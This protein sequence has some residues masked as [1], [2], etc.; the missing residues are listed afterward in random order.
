MTE[1]YLALLRSS[2]AFTQE[3][4]SIILNQLFRHAATGVVKDDSAPPHPIEIL[5]RPY[6]IE[7][8]KRP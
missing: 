1:T 5:T 4:R 3:E 7:L 8:V 6:P 2:Q